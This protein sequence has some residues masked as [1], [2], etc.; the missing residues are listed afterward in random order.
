MG[1]MKEQ[2]IVEKKRVKSGD[3]VKGMVKWKKGKCMR[4][5]EGM[6]RV[7]DRVEKVVGMV[8]WEQWEKEEELGKVEVWK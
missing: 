4:K 1:V 6:E 7:L 3:R 5:K 2:E 8:G